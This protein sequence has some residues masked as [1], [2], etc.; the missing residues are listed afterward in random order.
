MTRLLAIAAFARHASAGTQ[1]QGSLGT[2]I[3]NHGIRT[4]HFCGK[5]KPRF[6]W[7]S[8]KQ[9]RCLNRYAPPA[10]EPSATDSELT[11]GAPA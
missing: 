3:I 7:Y 10:V 1:N 2:V 8:N 5:T 6:A 4:A 9:P 11:G